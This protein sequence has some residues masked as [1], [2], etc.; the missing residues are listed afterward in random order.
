[1]TQV[2]PAARP[3]TAQDQKQPATTPGRR[4]GRP[5]RFE[6]RTTCRRF[7]ILA[8]SAE[9]ACEIVTGRAMPYGV[10]PAPTPAS[11]FCQRGD[12]E[13]C[14]PFEH[15]HQTAA[16]QAWLG[17]HHARLW[18]ERIGGWLYGEG[19]RLIIDLGP[20]EAAL[21][22]RCTRSTPPARSSRWPRSRMR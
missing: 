15:S 6:I 9:H 17:Q 5:H 1:M 12:G 18:G 19:L 13:E 22:V 3:A 21:N 10:P 7:E 16:W 8:E 11:V 20:A 14:E 2:I 4:A